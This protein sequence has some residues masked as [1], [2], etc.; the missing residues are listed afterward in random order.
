M[1]KQLLTLVSLLV[2]FVMVNSVCAAQNGS[3]QAQQQTQVV[4]QGVTNQIQTENNNQNANAANSG[5]GLQVQQQEQQQLQDGTDEGNQVQ[6]QNQ[7]QFGLENA[8]Q[9]KS[10]VANAVQEML[11][12]AE[13]NESIGQQIKTIAQIQNQNQIKIEESFKKVQSRNGFVSFFIGHDYKEI[14]N[15][16]KKIKQNLAQIDL[17][18]QFKNQLTGEMDQYN[19]SEQIQ[20]LKETNL[21]IEESLKNYE[22]SFSLFG[23]AFKLFSK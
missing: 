3:N 4:N 18:N 11:Q 16:E 2:I 12:I 7:S 19:L 22:K 14:N 5:N 20:I 17:L 1:K 6:Q 15:A 21:T 13:G 8:Q 23:W 9:R 10:R